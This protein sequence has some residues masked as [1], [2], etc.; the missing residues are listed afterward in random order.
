MRFKLT[1]PQ[2]ESLLDLAEQLETL[3][4]PDYFNSNTYPLQFAEPF[5]S[6][7]QI[8]WFGSQAARNNLKVPFWVIRL[9][10]NEI[11]SENNENQESNKSL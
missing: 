4:D 10:E 5:M 11:E 8:K 2:R 3:V 6:F 7:K 1:P 9:N